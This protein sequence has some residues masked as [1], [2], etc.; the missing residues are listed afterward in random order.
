MT[1]ALPD[2]YIGLGGRILGAVAL[3]WTIDCFVAFYLTFPLRLRTGDGRSG[4]SWP[5]RWAPSWA[6]RWRAG[7]FRINFDIQRA[8]GLW[9]FAMLFT[10]AWSSVCFNLNEVY[11]P[12]MQTLLGAERPQPASEERSAPPPPPQGAPT[13][14][15]GEAR[16]RGRILLSAKA[17]REGFA[18]VSER[19]LVSDRDNGRYAMCAETRSKRGD[20]DEECV[21]FAAVAAAPDEIPQPPLTPMTQWPWSATITLWVTSLHLARVFGLPMI[22]VC[23][24]GFVI[25]A[26]SITGV[27]I[28]VEKRGARRRKKCRATG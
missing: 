21:V 7:A 17:E 24:M 25:A 20:P 14:G 22:I 6:I 10:F 11:Q 13:L 18:I 23:V 1:L 5:R 27:Y 15:W 26:L 19:L 3:L 16:A 2:G 28:F 8:F 12:V 4:K 9:T